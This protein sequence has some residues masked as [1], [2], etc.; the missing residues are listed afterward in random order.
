MW[1]KVLLYLLILCPVLTNCS[2]EQQPPSFACISNFEEYAYFPANWDLEMEEVPLPESW[3][4]VVALPGTETPLTLTS[5]EIS[6]TFDSVSEIWVHRYEGMPYPIDN[7]P[8][9]YFIYQPKTD[10]LETISTKVKD[11]QIW[12]SDLFVMSDGSVWGQN[13]WSM[14]IDVSY[15]TDSI[16]AL[17]KYN[18]ETKEFELVPDAV[19]IPVQRNLN[20]SVHNTLVLLDDH[21]IFW[22]FIDKQ[23]LYKYDPANSIDTMVA[24]FPNNEAYRMALA[25]DGTIYVQLGLTGL[26]LQKGEIVQYFPETEEIQNIEVP[27]DTWPSSPVSLVVDSKGRLWTGSI[28]WREPDGTWHLLHPDK[29]DYFENIGNSY[30]WVPPRLILESSRY[31]WFGQSST[32][33]HTG[34]AWYDPSTGEGC[35]FTT[36]DAKMIEDANQVLWLVNDGYLYKYRLSQ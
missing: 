19:K 10:T 34:L 3:E 12:V 33:W 26:G 29:E 30:L 1:K 20:Q 28:G 18:E 2:Q 8:R 35:W 15:T 14:D 17:S 11:E 7:S 22:V 23:G 16:P 4:Q 27:E 24:E 13:I 32:P 25:K 6:R 36:V 21:D 9:T 5:V 31:Y